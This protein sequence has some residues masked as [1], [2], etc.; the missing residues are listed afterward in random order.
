MKEVSTMSY[1]WETG[2]DYVPTF[3]L[4]LSKGQQQNSSQSQTLW[5]INLCL[6]YQTKAKKIQCHQTSQRGQIRRICGHREYLR[7]RWNLLHTVQLAKAVYCQNETSKLIM[8]ILLRGLILQSKESKETMINF[9][10]S[11]TRKFEMSKDCCS[12]TRIL[13][14]SFLF[15]CK[16]RRMLQHVQ[17]EGNSRIVSFLSHGRS[18]SVHD[19]ATFAHSILPRFFP[20]LGFQDFL[21]VIVQ[22][23]F[24]QLKTGPDRGSFYH[25]L[26]LRCRPGL[27]VNMRKNSNK[28]PFNPE[29]QPNFYEYPTLPDG[30]M[31][32]PP[33]GANTVAA[34]VT[35]QRPAGKKSHNS[36]DVYG[37]QTKTKDG[38]LTFF[39]C[40]WLFDPNNTQCHPILSFRIPRIR[41]GRTHILI[42]TL[43]CRDHP[44]RN[45]GTV[46]LPALLLLL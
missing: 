10:R 46:V 20:N 32:P 12:C 31:I 24:E 44:P 35:P 33:S 40:Y 14:Y 23:G 21:E 26:F 37:T 17:I 13:L 7:Y 8:P 11:Y 9:P 43:L 36:D 41:M 34:G 3:I 15:Y 27:C 6:P 38:I 5:S 19:E 2:R 1:F 18:F 25:E 42:R 22:Y 39:I 16:N 30:V 45:R 28:Q 29:C 4:L